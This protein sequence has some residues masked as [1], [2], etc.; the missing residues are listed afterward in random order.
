MSVREN[1]WRLCLAGFAG[2]WLVLAQPAVGQEDQA[3]PVA[4]VSQPRPV[5]AGHPLASR[6]AL[7]DST[8][9]IAAA[10]DTLRAAAIRARLAEGGFKPGEGGWLRG[11]SEAALGGTLTQPTARH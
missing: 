4:V 10:G 8:Q 6:A 5:T 9:R 7:L 1:G 2:S 3:T 11:D